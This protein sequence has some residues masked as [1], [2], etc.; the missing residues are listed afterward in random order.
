MRPPGKVKVEEEG[1]Q[2]RRR[3][4]GAA[5]VRKRMGRTATWRKRSSNC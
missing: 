2:R 4:A 3:K 1:R 5:A